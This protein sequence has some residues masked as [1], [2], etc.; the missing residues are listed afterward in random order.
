[1]DRRAHRPYFVSSRALAYF[2]HVSFLFLVKEDLLDSGEEPQRVLDR[3][4]EL[5]RVRR[6]ESSFGHLIFFPGAASA[7]RHR[8]H[9]S[10]Y[11]YCACLGLIF[12]FYSCFCAFYGVC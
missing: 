9:I 4:Q 7:L 3:R 8:C 12:E 1:M 10:H 6:V 2:T 5:R 11:A